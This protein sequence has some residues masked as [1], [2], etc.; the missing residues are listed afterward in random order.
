MS[1]YGSEALEHRCQEVV[2]QITFGQSRF[3]AP[4]PSTLGDT[5]PGRY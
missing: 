1:L 5:W 4:Q 2:R 3:S